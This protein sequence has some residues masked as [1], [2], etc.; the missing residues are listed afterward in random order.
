MNR[1]VH[2]ELRADDI[3]RA[4]EFYR[5]A[6]G[7]NAQD[8]GGDPPYLFLLTGPE[9]KAGIH[10]AVVPRQPGIAPV[11]LTVEVDAVEEAMARVAAVG[12]KVLGGTNT[13]PGVGIFASIE[14]SEG[15]RFTLI[16]RLAAGG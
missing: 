10:G 11:E 13:I 4:T 8:W 5:V 16:Q 7:W 9:E 12:G 15:N 3:D 14:D 2:F 1:V 6:F